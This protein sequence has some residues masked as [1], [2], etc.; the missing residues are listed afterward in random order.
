MLEIGKTTLIGILIGFLAASILY[1]Q[2]LPAWVPSALTNSPLLFF[3]LFILICGLLGFNWGITETQD[4]EPVEK[5]D[6]KKIPINSMLTFSF[7][8]FL[9]AAV[10]YRKYMPYWVPIW[11][12]EYPALFFVCFALSGAVIG[13]FWAFEENN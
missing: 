6:K 4:N 3:G 10:L 8:G 7:T 2:Y 13:Y 12:N 1:S 11:F 9:V 5:T